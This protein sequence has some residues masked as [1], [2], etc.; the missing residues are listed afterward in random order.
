MNIRGRAASGTVLFNPAGT[1][2]QDH[3]VTSAGRFLTLSIDPERARFLREV[4]RH[5]LE[6]DSIA[7]K[8]PRARWLGR[9]L[10]EELGV[11]DLFHPRARGVG[12]RAHRTGHARDEYWP[13]PPWLARPGGRTVDR[14]LRR[15]HHCRRDCGYRRGS[16]M[17]PHALLPGG[18]RLHA[19]AVPAP[20]PGRHGLGASQGYPPLPLRNRPPL[21]FR[22]PDS[23]TR[24]F[25]KTLGIT[26]GRCRSAY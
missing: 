21:R 1:T 19:R 24:S 4:T 8:Q 2:H 20:V 3:F 15:S 26:P 5:S 7:L 17:A 23:V 18:V 14:S 6:G 16:S 10:N 13:C 9:R 12:A 22:G 11:S 25:R